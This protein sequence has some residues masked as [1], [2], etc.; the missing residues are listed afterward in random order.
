MLKEVVEEIEVKHLKGIQAKITFGQ[1]NYLSTFSKLSLGSVCL[2]LHFS[3]CL[4]ICLNVYI[5]M[6]YS[7]SVST[8][9]LYVS[10]SIHLS[11]Y[12]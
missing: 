6:S 11:T 7:S 12:L 1:T 9:V 2:S 4:Y 10:L 5:I 3:V 8:S